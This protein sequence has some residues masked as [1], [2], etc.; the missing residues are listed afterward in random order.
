MFTTKTCPNCKIAKAMLSDAGIVVRVVDAEVETDLA[1][2]YAILQA[3][4]LV[5]PT[6]D[7]V[8]VAKGIGE[9]RKFI[10]TRKA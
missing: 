8:G 5:Y 1:R 3:P 4:T 2:K 7:G 10:D 6:E 9:I